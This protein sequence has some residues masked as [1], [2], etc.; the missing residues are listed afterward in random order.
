LQQLSNVS[1]AIDS[2]QKAIAI[3]PGYAIAHNNLGA[4]LHAQGKA[5]EACVSLRRGIEIVPGYP[6]AH[7]NLGNALQAL[8]DPQAALASY[9]EAIRLRPG[10]FNACLQMGIVLESLE[11]RSE[12]MAVY[13]SLVVSSPDS[14]DAWHRLSLLLMVSNQWDRARTAIEQA[15]RF[16]VKSESLQSNLL[17]AKQML[18]DWSQRDSQLKSVMERVEGQLAAGEACGASPFFAI[19]FAWPAPLQRAIARAA[20]QEISTK[21]KGLRAEL[22]RERK[23]RLPGRLRIGYLSGD[24]YDHAVSHLAQGMF[25]LHD[26]QAFEV[27]A[28]S[29][30]PNDHSGYRYCIEAN[31]EHF[32]D[33]RDLR[34]RAL[35]RRIASDGI[36]I[37][38][39]MMGF[40]GYTRLEAMAARAAP[41]QVSWL[42]YPGTTGSDFMDYVLGDR[43][44]TPATNAADFSEHL[45]QLPHS[46]LITDHQQPVA[47]R[48]GSRREHGLPEQGIVFACINNS[49]KFEPV[50]FE[51]WMR[52]LKQT[53]G[54]V[55]WLKSGGMTME[56]N[57]RQEAQLR[58]IEAER[59]LFARGILP[60]PDHLA[61]LQLADLFLD[62]HFYN[63]HTT[64]AD[65]LWAGLP[66]LTCPG[67]TFASRVAASMLSAVGLPELIVGDLKTYETTAIALASD[68][69]RLALLRARLRRDRIASPLFD[70]PLFVRGLESAY[71]AIWAIHESGERPH[72]I[73]LAVGANFQSF[74]SGK[75]Q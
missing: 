31:C 72:P 68:Q 47:E 21:Q 33:V 55:L 28:Y 53:P 40:S 41:V 70:T 13:E 3:D 20:A 16:A 17:Y 63:A 8:D 60:K 12:A 26:R 11:Q 64:A 24:F 52:I 44:I 57:L 23:P 14:G 69:A 27:F 45:L 74:P 43:W 2:Y 36:D 54:S 4:A 75:G 59:I 7:F 25:S 35:A 61:R 22:A 1:E 6:E 56:S 38:V 42:S 19:V 34:T 18:C 49:Y 51:V 46:Y 9:R 65:A 73:D 62:T 50:I 15:I 10:Y 39:D 29:Y 5:A 58:G 67:K 71:Q 66:V 32:V 48:S 37:L 30:G